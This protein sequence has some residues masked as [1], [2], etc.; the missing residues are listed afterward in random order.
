MHYQ[1]NDIMLVEADMNQNIQAENWKLSDEIMD[2]KIT[3]LLPLST[4]TRTC[5]HGFLTLDNS[6]CSLAMLKLAMLY[7]PNF[8]NEILHKPSK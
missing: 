2:A 8:T 6:A 7:W 5:M 1:F 4:C 3:F